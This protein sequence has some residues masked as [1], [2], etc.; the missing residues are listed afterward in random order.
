[1]VRVIPS[2][3]PRYCS[4][5]FSGPVPSLAADLLLEPAPGWLCVSHPRCR[6]E[7]EHLAPEAPGVRLTG[8]QASVAATDTLPLS[9]LEG[10]IISFAPIPSGAA[11]KGVSCGVH[12][13]VGLAH[14]FVRVQHHAPAPTHSVYVL[15]VCIH[16]YQPSGHA[17][18]SVTTV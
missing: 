8:P 6:H 9:P 14:S 16:L 7:F 17:T 15:I 18:V 11:C 13:V 10:S 3:G 2:F 1:M 4:P 12:R 5:A